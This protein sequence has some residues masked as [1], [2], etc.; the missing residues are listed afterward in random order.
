MGLGQPFGMLV[1]M[2][3]R[4]NQNPE[5]DQLGVQKESSSPGMAQP[6]FVKDLVRLPC[7]AEKG[8]R[9]AWQAGFCIEKSESVGSKNLVSETVFRD[10]HVFSCLQMHGSAIWALRVIF[11]PLLECPSLIKLLW[12]GTQCLPNWPAQQL[13]NFTNP[14]SCFPSYSADRCLFIFSAH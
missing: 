11:E 4:W 6:V 5:R 13:C 9:S 8:D 10:R 3:C 2:H 12:H 14:E 1:S 7:P